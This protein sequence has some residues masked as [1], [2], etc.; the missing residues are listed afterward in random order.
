MAFGPPKKRICEKFLKFYENSITT[1][2]QMYIFSFKGLYR[3][4]CLHPP[5]VKIFVYQSPSV[6]HGISIKLILNILAFGI[7]HY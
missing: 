3:L 4:S 6:T 7:N 2:T 1:H 5:I